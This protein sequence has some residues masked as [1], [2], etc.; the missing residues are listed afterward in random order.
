MKT[1]TV[2]FFKSEKITINMK[3]LKAIKLTSM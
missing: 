3:L 2:Y 1:P